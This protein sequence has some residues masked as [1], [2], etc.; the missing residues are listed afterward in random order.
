MLGRVPFYKITFSSPFYFSS[1]RTAEAVS[2]EAHLASLSSSTWLAQLYTWSSLPMLPAAFCMYILFLSFIQL[3]PFVL[4]FF[5]G[6]NHNRFQVCVCTYAAT[7]D[8]NQMQTVRRSGWKPDNFLLLAH[9]QC[10]ESAGILVY[11]N[12]WNM[13]TYAYQRICS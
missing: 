5:F 6:A 9:V 8:L 4:L 10:S 7:C 12:T 11:E 3:F 1:R 13:L 2:T